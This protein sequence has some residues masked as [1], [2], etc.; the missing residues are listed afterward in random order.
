VRAGDLATPYPKVFADDPASEV[1]RKMARLNV[2]AVLVLGRDDS[3]AGVVSDTW[4]LR[5]LLPRY[6]E[7]NHRLAAVLDEEAADVLWRQLE[8]KTARDIIPAD[9]PTPEVDS[10]DTLVTVAAVMVRTRSPVVAV[11]ERSRLLGVVT[12]EDLLDRLLSQR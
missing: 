12:I 9:Q 1:A 7:E 5:K 3:L 10:A 2:R 6:V 8:G 4:L 11:R